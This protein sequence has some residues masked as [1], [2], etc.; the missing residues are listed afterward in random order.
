MIYFGGVIASGAQAE[1]HAL[2]A[3]T[4]APVTG[5]LMGLGAFDATQPQWLGTLGMHGV[6]EA[7]LATQH[8][9]L[10]VAAGA[11]LDDRVIGDPV[12]FARVQRRIVHID[13][14]PSSITKRVRADIPIV[15]DCRQAPAALTS[16][17]RAA[18][19][20]SSRRT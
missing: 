20:A 12:D 9:D 18:P 17:A 2:A 11:R 19:I 10:L 13:I 14:D 5:T 7:N 4:G 15:G 3:L 1:L 8:C 16:I 6:A